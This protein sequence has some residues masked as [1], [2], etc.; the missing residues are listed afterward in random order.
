VPE[1]LGGYVREIRESLGSAGNPLPTVSGL[2]V[3]V[4]DYI[5]LSYTS[6][7][8]AVANVR[9][10][11]VYGPVGELT[12]TCVVPNANSVAYG[13]PVDN[14]TGN[15]VLTAAAVKESCSKA[16]VPALLALG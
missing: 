9:S 4:H 15:A 6:G 14:T 12:G 5:S 8:P 13:V 1:S 2:N 10:G 16:V 11:T 3:P 7:N